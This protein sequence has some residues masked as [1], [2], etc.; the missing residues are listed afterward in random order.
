MSD[1]RDYDRIHA[2]L[3]KRE[4]ELVLTEVVDALLD[5]ENPIKVWREYRRL[6]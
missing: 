4:E 6:S 5:R 2:A 3:K 1:L